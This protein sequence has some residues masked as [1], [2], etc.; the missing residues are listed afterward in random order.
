MIGTNVDRMRQKYA[1]KLEAM[2]RETLVYSTFL[3]ERKK[4]VIY[5]YLNETFEMRPH[6]FVLIIIMLLFKDT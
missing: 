1:F 5:Y 3:K 4:I 2:N 6:L